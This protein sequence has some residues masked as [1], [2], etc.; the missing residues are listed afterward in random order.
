LRGFA[1]ARKEHEAA[2]L[3]LLGIGPLE[4]DTRAIVPGLGLEAVV[5]PGRLAIRDWLE[6]AAV[7][8]HSSRWRASAS[9]CWRR[10]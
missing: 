9:C 2:F 4:A 10:C 1:E 3:A 5:M 6:R 7:F 8:A